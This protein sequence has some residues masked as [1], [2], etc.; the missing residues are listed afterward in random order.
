MKKHLLIILV[1]SFSFMNAQS[2]KFWKKQ[3]VSK[4]KII[5]NVATT[6]ESFP[7]KFDLYELNIEGLR[8]TLFASL[9]N[10][11]SQKT[12][13][14]L[15]NTNGQIEEFEM[16]EAS[17]F[18][19]ELQARFPEIRAYS[20]KG[21]TDKYATLKLSIS[22]QGIQTMVFRTDKP[23]EFIESYSKDNKVYAV[24]NSQRVRGNSKWTCST[25][26][27]KIVTDL[28]AKVENVQKSSA[29]QLKV[30]R[31]AQSCNAEYGN[32]FGATRSA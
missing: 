14:T 32:D 26:D 28:N 20:G 30:L 31:L 24:F 7:K 2:D 22:P 25:V 3:D 6:R 9:T 16:Y 18:D 4:S 19:V 29:G 8:S 13:I 15:P 17:N 1:F 23:N 12:I 27:E 11:S 21:I 10:K 5:P